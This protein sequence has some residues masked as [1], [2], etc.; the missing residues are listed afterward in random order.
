MVG[1]VNVHAISSAQSRRE[2]A[3][4]PGCVD[5]GFSGQGL[6]SKVDQVALRSSNNGAANSLLHRYPSPDRPAYSPSRP[7]TVFRPS[8]HEKSVDIGYHGDFAI[9][10]PADRANSGGIQETKTG[11][12]LCK[13]HQSSSRQWQYLVWQVASKV[14]WSAALPAQVQALW[15][16]TFW[17]QIQQVQHWLVPLQ[18]CCVTTQASTA[19]VK[20]DICVLTGRNNS[21]DRRRGCT[22]AAVFRV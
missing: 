4:A 5:G 9:D 12:R 18:A 19:A 13:R 17:A 7:M 22:P 6:C 16:Q 10:L 11:S 8:Q 20:Q 15:L 21:E 3:D 14:I 2:S 1:F